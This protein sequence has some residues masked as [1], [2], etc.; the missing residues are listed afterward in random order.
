MN[1]THNEIKSDAAERFFRT[2]KNK[3]YKYMTAISE[4]LY[5]DKLDAIVLKTL[6]S[7]MELLKCSLLMLN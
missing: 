2:V 6:V 7:N 1:L 4:N 3:I 5:I